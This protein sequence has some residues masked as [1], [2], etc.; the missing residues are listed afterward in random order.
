MKTSLFSFIAKTAI[1]IA[2]AC[3]LLMCT[4]WY[5]FSISLTTMGP[6]AASPTAAQTTEMW[7]Q[8]IFYWGVS[9][10]CFAILAIAW[11][12]SS[13]IKRDELFS[14]NVAKRIKICA[15]ILFADL[16]AFIAGNI[17][18]MALGWNDFAIVYFVIAAVGAAVACLF[19]IAAHY[20]YSAA[21]LQQE[22]EGMI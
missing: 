18:F 9:L 11:K 5:P 13:A 10:P 15:V 16:A 14:Y 8:L 12:V 19:L 6:V 20:I 22:T 1:I 2:A 7:V 17:I 3:G 21:N 4:L